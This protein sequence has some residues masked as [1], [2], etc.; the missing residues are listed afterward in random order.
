MLHGV[1]LAPS[2]DYARRSRHVVHDVPD[3]VRGDHPGA[4]L[5]RLRRAHEVLGRS[6][7]S[8]SCGRRSSTSRSRTG[9]GGADGW[10]FADGRAR[11]RRRHGR[12]PQLRRVGARRRPHDRQAAGHDQERSASRTTSP[13]TV[14]GA[15]ILWFGWFGFN[16]GSALRRRPRGRAFGQHPPRRGRRGAWPGWWS[17]GCTAA[18]RDARRRLRRRRRPRRDHARGGL[19]DPVAARSSSA[20][21]R[22]S[23]AT[24]AVLSRASSATTTRSTPSASTASAASSAR[25][26]RH[27]R[28][29][30][31]PG[32]LLRPDRRQPAAGGHPGH[33]GRRRRPLRGRGHG[34]HRQGR[35]RPAGRPGRGPRSRRW[36]WTSRS[37]ARRLAGLTQNSPVRCPRPSPAKMAAG[38]PAADWE[39]P[40][41]ND[42]APQRQTR[43][44]SPGATPL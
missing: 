28:H 43:N 33:R 44:R 14:L 7:C 16:A 19:R 15:G 37:T 40:M 10:L 13:M 3:D 32:R 9:S 22:A 11:L 8:R 35:R 36:A 31:G 20:S 26:D 17:S 21:S 27:L 4:D 39:S 29:F 38:H 34:R 24:A 5:G 23:S 25:C 1:G 12:P 2:A 41:T 42:G 6:C 30:H 18:S